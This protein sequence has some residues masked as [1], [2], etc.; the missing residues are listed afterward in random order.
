MQTLA[1]LYRDKGIRPLVCDELTHSFSR[2]LSAIV[3]DTHAFQAV[4]RRTRSII[5]G[6]TALHHLLRSPNTWKPAD[7][8]L[9][10]P[11]H[12]Y[13]EV[14]E[15][16]LDIRGAEVIQDYPHIYD[17]SGFTHIIQIQTPLAKFDVIQSNGFSPFSPLPFYYGTHVMNAITADLVVSA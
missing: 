7:V 13:E 11:N 16:I 6:S 12:R 4:M 2:T 10:V 14:V 17:V 8:D 1:T 9:I 5:S 3:P 15:F